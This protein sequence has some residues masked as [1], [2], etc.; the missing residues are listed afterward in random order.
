MTTTPLFEFHLTFDDIDD[1]DAL[2]R[3]L[4]A[5]L[6]GRPV[7]V[8][9]RGGDTRTVFVTITPPPDWKTPLARTG[10]IYTVPAR[11]HGASV[12]F[13]E[14]DESAVEPPAPA[15]TPEDSR[16]T[17]Q[18]L[19]PVAELDTTGW[20]ITDLLELLVFRL[21][22]LADFPATGD[23]ISLADAWDRAW[24]Q[25]EG[26]PTKRVIIAALD[27][28][29]GRDPYP[30][31]LVAP[32]VDEFVP[33]FDAH[34][35]AADEAGQIEPEPSHDHDGHT[36]DVGPV[37]TD[38]EPQIA[39]AAADREAAD[40]YAVDTSPAP[41]DPDHGSPGF[42]N[43]GGSG[44]AGIREDPEGTNGALATS[45]APPATWTPSPGPLT[46]QVVEL[47]EAH[48]DVVFRPLVAEELLGSTTKL[49]RTAMS[50]LASK[51]RIRKLGRGLYQARDAAQDAPPDLRDQIVAWLTDHDTG[52]A[53][54]I[55][56][57]LDTTETVVK[58]ELARM[59][60]AGVTRIGGRGWVLCTATDTAARHKARRMA[61]VEAM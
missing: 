39:G 3:H 43:A 47:L 6:P 1:A 35:A 56:E 30:F 57:Q 8:D 58:A 27:E 54:R 38:H 48:P 32:I 16:I 42:E 7:Q 36:V 37:D 12:D 15:A 5:R 31:D 60:E 18:L 33:L 11:P 13:V 45:P 20:S 2:M 61:A 10:A 25:F 59:T 21:R 40:G 28:L 24:D 50:T 22:A 9:I 55:A 19:V 4:E 41:D 17:G 14:F 52:S 49:V 51:G 53:R 26:M 44:D 46:D 34:L 23:R 29:T